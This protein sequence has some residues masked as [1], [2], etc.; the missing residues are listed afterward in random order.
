MYRVSMS[1]AAAKR[2]STQIP[3]LGTPA[4]IGV[5]LLGAVRRRVRA[6]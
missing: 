5:V 2:C 3:E 6:A 1:N 4:L